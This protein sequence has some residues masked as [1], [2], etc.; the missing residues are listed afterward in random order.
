MSD[1]GNKEIL[2]KNLKKYIDLSGKD[3][4]NIAKDLQVSYSTFTDWING[5]SYPRIDKIEKM[6][7]YFGVR[8]SDLIEEHSDNYYLNEESREI[9]NEILSNP[10]LKAIVTAARDVSPADLLFVKKMLEKMKS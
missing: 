4:K 5:N 8:K 7:N 2:S 6:A 10:D 3:R 1:L 9:A